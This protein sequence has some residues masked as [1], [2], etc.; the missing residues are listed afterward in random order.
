MRSRR[1]LT[2]DG[3]TFCILGPLEIRA[4]ERV[5]GL[6]GAKQ[7]A[8]LLRLLLVPGQVVP[9]ERL[10]EDVWDDPPGSAAHAVR[11][12]AST[13]RKTVGDI[14]RARAGGYV[15]DVEPA[16]IDAVR[17][18]RD[19][20]AGR[21]ALAQGEPERASAV[22]SDTLALWRGPPL[23]DVRYAPW[24]QGEIAR[25]EELRLAALE[26]RVDA[27]LALGRATELVGELQS[28][29]A[30][31]PLRERLRRQLMLAL[32]RSGRQTDA[33]S[34]YRDARRALLDELGL[35]PG[36][37][38]RA[39]ERSIL[40]QDPALDVEPAELR[41][42]RRLPAPTT[43]LVGRQREVA[44]VVE[45]LSRDAR[46]VTLSGPGGTGKTRLALEAAHELAVRFEDGVDFVGLSALRDP[47][48]VPGEIA[49]ALAVDV[50]SEPLAD[51]AAHL[52]TRSSLLVLDNFEQVDEAAPALA[53][54]LQAA[55]RL[56]LLV[57]S[58]H[59]LRLYGEH[60][61]AV[62]PLELRDEAVPLFIARAAAAGRG[63]VR[64]DSDVVEICRR[65]DCLP[66]ALELAAGRARE[67][68]PA[69]L[70]LAL[71]ERLDVAS[72]GPRDLPARQQTLRATIDWSYELLD[73]RERRLFESLGTFAGGWDED[74]A[75]LVAG[76]S[77]ER[78]VELERR[79]L[80]VREA[81]RW[82]MLET[83][84]ESAAERL[85][86]RDDEPE[87]RRRHAEHF[88]SLA[89]REDA[90]LAAGGGAAVSLDR[91]ELE[92]DNV[93]GAIDWA[94]A[95]GEI[96]L[97]L[98]LVTALGRFWEWRGH[99]REGL[100][101]LERALASN[102]EAPVGLRSRA[103][104]RAG[105]FRHIQ[106]D[107]SGARRP[108]EE[109]LAAAR[110]NGDSAVAA[111]ALRNLGALAKDAGDADRARLLHEEALELSRAADDTAGVSSSLMNLAD[112]ALAVGDHRQAEAISRESVAVARVLGNDLREFVS[113]LNLGLALVL[114]EHAD[115]ALEPLKDALQLCRRLGYV[116]GSADVLL[117]A[118]A[119][120]SSA[121]EAVTAA[122]LLGAA[123]SRLTDA[124][125]MLEAGERLIRER[126]VQRLDERLG[127]DLETEIDR[128]RELPFEPALGAAFD[129]L[130][131]LDAAALRRPAT[132]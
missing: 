5:L 108:M 98:R 69:K 85:E 10:M 77:L 40:R 112:V 63:S 72:G 91:L 16:A 78:L 7:R 64:P 105:V 127:D 54:L 99:G 57:T 132:T 47:R 23:A 110:A 83:I 115:E 60:E 21:R 33:L 74:A 44:D 109:A 65:L 34:A 104:L 4:G 3:L 122:R 61:Y 84:R 53:S 75:A 92:H 71:A 68:P 8:L 52:R 101:R 96:A 29:V 81:G 88:A 126:T 100:A 89:E 11:V 82:S 50:S 39:L 25:L 131:K 32:Y 123:E 80:V 49:A 76:G 73:A 55:P 103:L 42:R 51:L 35:E 30:A 18:A 45:L 24:A 113:L 31:E 121:G 125:A 67:L 106:G 41:A 120:L 79:S 36:T 70:R 6:G 14:V 17:F 1:R 124:G 117:G 87:L 58:R 95:A 118:A 22:L 26:E 59:R 102:A 43:P 90:A 13:L 19:M 12:Y 46:L 62:A 27:D 107:L 28:L 66:L 111:N 56:R 38:L 128:G 9:I 97:E 130:E 116:A 94:A 86:R 93:R 114:G 2:T 20:E 119:V 37:E 48:L 129:A 15:L